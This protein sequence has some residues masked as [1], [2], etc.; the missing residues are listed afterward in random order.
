MTNDAMAIIRQVAAQ[1]GVS[2]DVLRS[3]RFK[4]LL[5]EPRMIVCRRLRD[6]RRLS[7]LQIGRLLGGRHHTTILAYLKT[8]EHGQRRIAT[9]GVIGIHLNSG[10]KKP[11]RVCIEG[12]N[13][14]HFKHLENAIK[15]RAN[16][17]QQLTEA[18]AHAR[19]TAQQM[20]AGL[21]GRQLRAS[22]TVSQTGVQNGN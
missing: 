13:Y 19:E 6:E 8:Y 3:K 14:G 22:R 7:L 21:R 5:V 4:Y 2:P 17:L 20:P 10:E 1:F 18:G 12:A 15:R 9:S 16:V 11:W